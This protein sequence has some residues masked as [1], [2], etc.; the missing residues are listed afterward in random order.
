[1]NINF[2]RRINTFLENEFEKSKFNMVAGGLLS[3]FGH[4]IYYAIYTFLLPQNYDS[5]FFRFTSSLISIPLFFVFRYPA[6]F[7]SAITLYWYAWIMFVLPIT[8]TFL[9]LMNDISSLWLIAETMMIFLTFIMGFN[10]FIMAFIILSGAI[11]GYLC[12]SSY[13]GIKLYLQIEIIEYLMLVP[14]I[15]ISTIILKLNSKKGEMAIEEERV[16]SFKSLAGSIAHEMRNPLGS[17]RLATENLSQSPDSDNVTNFKRQIDKTI[18][19]AGDIIDI[20]L[21]E[22]SGKKFNKDDFVY[23]TAHKAVND[24]VT[25]YGYANNEEK[26]KVFIDFGNGQVIDANQSDSKQI[27]VKDIDESNNFIIHINDTAFKYII[28]NLI[29]NALF[30]LKDYPKSKI[31]ISFEQS[32]QID[33]ALITKFKLNPAITSYNVVNV[34]DT[35]PGISDEIIVKIFDSYFTSGK[36]GGT[37]VGLDFC[38]RVME[39]FGGGIVCESELGKYTKFSLLL[40]ILEQ[41][42]QDGAIKQI[43]KIEQARSYSQESGQNADALERKLSSSVKNILLLDDV[44]LNIKML[45]KALNK[46]CPNFDITL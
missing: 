31:E 5:I 3:F 6:K 27:S 41:E 40:P 34:M 11:I 42:E 13:S 12:F 18:D 32:K 23:Y 24:A 30:Y 7:K 4:P 37:G 2:F 29:K 8:F 17:I 15:F 19:L 16:N 25:I 36:K 14:L 39:D 44:E 38:A 28:F 35:G 22:L 10:L 43:G 46:R 45:A 1:M 9:L 21:H 33:V 20:T 26:K